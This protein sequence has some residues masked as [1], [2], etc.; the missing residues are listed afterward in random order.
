M[1]FDIVGGG[2]YTGVSDGRIIRWR[3]EELRWVDFAVT[4]SKRDGCIGPKDDTQL[5]HICG[6]PLGLGFY[7]KTG[8][9]YIADA[10]LGLLVVGPNGGQASPVSTAVDGVPF[11]FTNALGI[12][13]NSGVVYFTDSST[14][15][16]RR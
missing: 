2:P 12:D 16:T 1:A 10:Y 8:E 11:G 6:R 5:E 15:F 9:L 3:A 13:Q 7:K 14:R 4:S